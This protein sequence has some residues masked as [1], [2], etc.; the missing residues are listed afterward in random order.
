MTGTAAYAFLAVCSLP[1]GARAL[2]TSLPDGVAAG[3]IAMRQPLLLLDEPSAY[4]DPAAA[5]QVIRLVRRLNQ[6]YG[7]TFI[8]VTHD[9]EFA[10]ELATRMVVMEA[11]RIL[12]DGTPREILTDAA[13]L[14]RA[15]LEPPTLT[16]L[17]SEGAEVGVG[18]IPVTM[19]EAHTLLQS[20]RDR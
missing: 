18:T 11:G 4:L 15:R 5:Q 20:W 14:R 12:D 1:H 7:Y 2:E 17:F 19:A 10:A 6:D 16:K 9:M 8:I 13:L 3:L